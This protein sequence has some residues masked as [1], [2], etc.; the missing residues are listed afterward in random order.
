MNFGLILA[1]GVGQ[2]MR[3]SG[4]PKQFLEV[5]GKPIII[6]TL[7]KFEECDDIEKI[8]ISCNTSWIDYLSNLVM[9]QF[10]TQST[11]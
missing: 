4:M 3:S 9:K 8:V 7:E 6:F 5:F 10:A 11:L 1:G 2:R